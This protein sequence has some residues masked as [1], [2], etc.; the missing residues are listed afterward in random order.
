MVLRAV[1]E[2]N[3]NALI[4]NP[5]FMIGPYDTKPSSGAL[6]LALYHKKI[7]GYTSGAKNYIAV[8]D[9]AIAISNAIILGEVGECYIL[10]NH[11]LSYKKALQLMA[12]VIGVNCPKI[13]LPPFA[14]KCYGKINSLIGSVL[15][16]SP[17]ITKELAQISCEDHCYSGEKAR[18]KLNMPC[19]DLQ[20][21]VKECFEWFQKNSYLTK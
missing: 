11:N 13:M 16:T 18:Q 3:L 2:Q 21:A 19:T 17:S 14:V 6:I 1:N 7:P 8:K 12:E 9:A 4:V 20:I 15:K 5:T 10:G